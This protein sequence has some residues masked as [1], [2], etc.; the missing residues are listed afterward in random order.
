MKYWADP[1]AEVECNVF[2]SICATI[3]AGTCYY[4]YC[5]GL[6]V[7][8]FDADFEV[9]KSSLTFNCGEFA[10]IK[11]ETGGNKVAKITVKNTEINITK[12]NDEDY[13]CITDM[14]KN[15]FYN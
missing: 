5:I 6:L 15:R 11:N 3:S 4:T 14:L 13:I 9:V 2:V 10:I 7:P 12:I 8:F 1:H